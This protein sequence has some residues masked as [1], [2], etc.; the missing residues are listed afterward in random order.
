MRTR[1]F[2]QTVAIAIVA[3]LT[4]M[5]AQADDFFK[6]GGVRYKIES[7]VDQEL[8]MT[9]LGEDDYETTEIIIPGTIKTKQGQIWT[10]TAIGAEA[11]NNYKNLRKLSI[12]KTVKHIHKDAMDITSALHLDEL[13]LDCPIKLSSWFLNHAKAI[14]YGPSATEETLMFP[15]ISKTHPMAYLGE[16]N[17]VKVTLDPANKNL[18]MVDGVLY[19]KSKTK[20]L[21]FPRTKTGAFTVPST[22]KSIPDWAFHKSGITSLTFGSSITSISK[23]ACAG[24]ESLVRV[25]FLG[26]VENIGW[27]AFKGCKLLKEIKLPEGLSMIDGS[28]FFRCGLE[29]LVIPESVTTIGSYAF[30]HANFKK[31]AIPK[32]VTAIGPRAFTDCPHLATVEIFEGLKECHNE[33]F[34]GSKELK[35]ILCHAETPQ[36]NFPFYSDYGGKYVVKEIHVPQ[37]CKAA[38]ENSDW[39]RDGITIIDDL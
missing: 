29:N 7:F 18:V 38:Y 8:C 27:D 37:G 25:V 16:H 19:N 31:I 3:M 2:F 36:I 13:S 28:V 20:L 21:Y 15:T 6:H 14:K 5:S 22:V 11:F 23:G 26:K 34:F 12:P 24:C 17:D 35:T 10:V 32:A 30:S 33:A 9:F 39:N 1:Q 4:A